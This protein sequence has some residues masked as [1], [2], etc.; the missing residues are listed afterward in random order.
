MGPTF[1]YDLE[2]GLEGGQKVV[3]YWSRVSIFRYLAVVG[4]PSMNP[5]KGWGIKL[6]LFCSFSNIAIGMMCKPLSFVLC[7]QGMGKTLVLWVY[8]PNQ[9]PAGSCQV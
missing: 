4:V 7:M 2:V 8:A 9:E 1:L 6:K 3:N 5:S